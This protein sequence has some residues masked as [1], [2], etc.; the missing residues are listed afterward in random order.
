M[1]TLEEFPYPIIDIKLAQHLV[2]TEAAA[3]IAVPTKFCVLLPLRYT[4]M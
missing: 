1:L 4:V 2:G 3:N